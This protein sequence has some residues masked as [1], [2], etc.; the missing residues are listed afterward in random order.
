MAA[1]TTSFFG[2]WKSCPEFHVQSSH[3]EWISISSLSSAV[4]MWSMVWMK[5][6]GLILAVCPEEI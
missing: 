3:L 6:V 4:M 1:V 2:G 5:Q